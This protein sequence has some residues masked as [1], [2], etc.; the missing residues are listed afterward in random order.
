M[1]LSVLPTLSEIEAAAEVAVELAGVAALADAVESE[2]GAA[3]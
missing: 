3:S 2:N 1:A